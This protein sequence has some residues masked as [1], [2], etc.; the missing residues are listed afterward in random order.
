MKSTGKSLEVMHDWESGD[1][2]AAFQA[3]IDV[4]RR[5][6]ED[7]SAD[8]R[9]TDR[10]RL[11]VKTE[12]LK[13]DPPDI[14]F[15]WP[16][17]NLQPY[18]DADVLR[19]V[20][21]V[22]RDNDLETHYLDGPIDLSRFD[23]RYVAVPMNIHRINNL[24]YNI[25]YVERKGVD[26]S[27]IDSPREF[28]EALQQIEDDN[29]VHG[30]IQPMKDPWPVVQLW[31]TV[32]LGQFGLDTYR[33]VIG[34]DASANSGAIGESLKIVERYTDFASDDALFLGLTGAQE[35]FTG[36][37]TAFFFQGDWSVGAFEAASGFDFRTD[38][39]YVPFPGTDGKYSMNMDAALAAEMSDRRESIDAFL[40]TAGSVAGQTAFNK[41]KGSIPPRTDVPQAEFSS[42]QQTQMDSFERSRSQPPSIAH[43]LAVQP[44]Q[45]IELL[46]TFATFVTSR[47]IEKTRRRL[48][49]IFDGR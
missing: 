28:V 37:E 7:M 34:G 11:S 22:W 29:D 39:E 23:D 13:R 17:K 27:A 8:E 6:H 21:D 12:L 41:A 49:K 46:T 44:G 19:D 15:D 31:A 10:V 42:F 30:L 40:R 1:G 3:M 36:G 20:T 48:I 25:E 47:D 32:L 45:R 24:F 33:S 14:W 18:V 38:W 26:P 4:F 35:R 2:E 5:Q 9:S 43:G 16:G